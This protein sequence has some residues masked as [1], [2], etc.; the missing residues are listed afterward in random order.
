MSIPISRFLDVAAACN[1]QMINYTTISS[2]AQVP[3]STVKSYFQILRDTLI[4]DTLPAWKK[5][6]P[7]V[8]AWAKDWWP[9]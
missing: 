3:L 9:T 2:D 7:P 8:S 6:L 1:G 4:A 5:S